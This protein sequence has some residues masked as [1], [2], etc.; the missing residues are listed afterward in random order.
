MVALSGSLL[1]WQQLWQQLWYVQLELWERSTPAPPP[2][3]ASPSCM[4]FRTCSYQIFSK[5]DKEG[6]NALSW[7]DIQD[8]VYGQSEQSGGGGG[9][10]SRF[11]QG[12]STL[13]FA[14]PVG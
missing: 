4:I 13:R 1:L 11:H 9:P 8:L 10:L 5:Y 7:R 6:K 14:L 2:P 12:G 3:L